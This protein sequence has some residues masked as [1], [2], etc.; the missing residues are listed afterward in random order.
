MVTFAQKHN[1]PAI[2]ENVYHPA[3]PERDGFLP[4][5]V[6]GYSLVMVN[7]GFP[8]NIF[9]VNPEEETYYNHNLDQT[10]DINCLGQDTEGTLWWI[11]PKLGDRPLHIEEK[12]VPFA[13]A[14][15]TA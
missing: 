11:E 5:P 8:N 2:G 9:S 14:V 3:F 7:P 1:V 6:I 12:V 10:F 13:G 15:P 4:K